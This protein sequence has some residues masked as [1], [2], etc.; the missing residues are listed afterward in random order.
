MVD[1]WTSRWEERYEQEMDYLRDEAERRWADQFTELWDRL[2]PL[3]VLEGVDWR[4]IT[5]AELERIAEYVPN[6]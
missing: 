3:G 5:L 6:R 2:E 4:D 1:T